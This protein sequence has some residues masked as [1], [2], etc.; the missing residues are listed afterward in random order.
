MTGVVPADAV[1]TTRLTLGYRSAELLLDC[2]LGRRGARL[3][4][5]EYHYSTVTP[6]GPALELRGRHGQ[7]HA[8]FATPRLLASYLHLH[9]GGDPTPAEQFVATAGHPS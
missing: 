8:G 6:D 4:G 7:G 3:R 5:H 1:M 2:P 9:L